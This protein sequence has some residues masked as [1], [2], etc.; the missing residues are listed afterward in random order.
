MN[1]M[2]K[3]L[4]EAEELYGEISVF[5]NHLRELSELGDLRASDMFEGLRDINFIR[6]E[7]GLEPWD[8]VKLVTLIQGF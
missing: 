8:E 1:K 3:T 2:K 6:G 7:A 5:V 4:R